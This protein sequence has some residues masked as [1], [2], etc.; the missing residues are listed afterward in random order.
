MPVDL[1]PMLA[2]VSDEAFNDAG[3][4]F[5]I[6]WDGY[7]ALSYLS[8]GKAE[9]RS[10]NNLPFNR[11]YPAL[12]NALKDWPV[13][14]V[15]DGEVVILK[16]N[17][18]PDFA[19]LQQWDKKQEGELLYYVFDLLWLEGI[20]LRD[21]PLTLRKEILKKLMPDTGPLRYSDSIDECG[22]DFFS[23]AKENCLEG[24][25]AKQKDA[26]YRN[27]YKNGKLVKNKS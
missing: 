17:G 16:E 18:H 3:W 7:R 13:N 2:S 15:I 12:V 14:A 4:Q 20:D 6:K 22:I 25:I 8:N 19:A 27:R 26:P 24:I 11:K 21:E 9:M 1:K 23:A 10:R 5:E